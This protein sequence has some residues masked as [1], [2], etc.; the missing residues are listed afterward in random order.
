VHD[1]HIRKL[2]DQR[3]KALVTLNGRSGS[4]GALDFDDSAVAAT[5]LRQP[6]ASQAPLQIRIRCNARNIER[7]IRVNRTVA[8]ENRNTGGTCRFEDFG[9]AIDQDRREYHRVDMR[10]DKITDLLTLAVDVILGVGK[11]QGQTPSFGLGLHVCRKCR[12]PAALRTCLRKADRLTGSLT[13]KERSGQERS[14][15][16]E[17]SNCTHL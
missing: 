9:P 1:P 7:G 17:N 11:H 2:R 6:R 15:E 13:C 12:A 4:L 10:R 14:G 8:N 3:K 5:C 16:Q